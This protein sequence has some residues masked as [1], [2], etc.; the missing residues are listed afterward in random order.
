MRILIFF[1]IHTLFSRHFLIFLLFF[2]FDRLL[3]K[4]TQ[5]YRILDAHNVLRKISAFQ[6]YTF[7]LRPRT[8]LEHSNYLLLTKLGYYIKKKKKKKYK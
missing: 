2:N 1:F 5:L 6:K 7:C 3:L 8:R 4:I